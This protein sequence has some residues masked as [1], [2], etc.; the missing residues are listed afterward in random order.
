MIQAT[1]DASAEGPLP[2]LVKLRSA[3]GGGL[4]RKSRPTIFIMT[5]LAI[6]CIITAL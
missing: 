4:G 1:N 2:P 5:A 3:S 6:P